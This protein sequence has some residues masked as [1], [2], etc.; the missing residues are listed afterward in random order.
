MKN[1]LHTVSGKLVIAAGL[2]IAAILFAYTAV[3]A[4]M[5]KVDTETEVMAL[6]TQKAAHAA[7]QVAQ[8]LTI[9]TSA[10][11]AVS[12]AIS[13][14]IAEG[15]KSR[16][17]VIAL[18][19]PVA[20]QYDSVFG[21]WMSELVGP[22]A[23][24]LLTG[25]EG[26]NDQ[27]V[28]TAY[29]T[30]DGDGKVGFSTWSIDPENEYYAVPLAAKT[31]VIT[32]PYMSESGTLI[33]SISAPVWVDGKIVGLAGV[34]IS[35]NNLTDIINKLRPFEGGH[36]MLLANNGTWLANTDSAKADD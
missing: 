22:D 27:G 21:S 31:S 36:V 7:D 29:W 35:L 28:F 13:G 26:Q 5:A 1:P 34:D 11:K 15:G 14:Y 4:W 33:T 9:A 17:D 16:A 6:A 25:T 18:L 2:S 8:N 3:N 30:K 20:L 12:G 23:P 10:G 32:A 24:K 19:K